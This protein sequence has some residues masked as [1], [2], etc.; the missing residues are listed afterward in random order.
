M[1]KVHVYRRPGGSASWQA[2]VYVGGRRYRFSCRTD[3]KQTARE[4]ARQRG[5][6]LRARHNRGLIGLPEPVRMS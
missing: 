1:A 5:E 3:D 2:Q 6:E 4:Y